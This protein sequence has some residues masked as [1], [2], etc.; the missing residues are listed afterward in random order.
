ML[1]CMLCCHANVSLGSGGED[2]YRAASLRG[3]YSY[4]P[5]DTSNLPG[6]GD[7]EPDARTDEDF[8]SP[9][10]LSVS[11]SSNS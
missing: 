9:A 4:D 3:R 5:W 1:L 8:T 6:E 11:R 10:L 7:A 2:S